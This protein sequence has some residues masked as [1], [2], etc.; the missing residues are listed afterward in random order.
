MGWR[1][2]IKNANPEPSGSWRDT[3]QDAPIEPR[4]SDK[5][6]TVGRSL[7]EGV[8]AGLSEPVISGINAVLGN[9]EDAGRHAQ[10]FQ[11]FLSKSFDW[12]R[13]KS[14]YAADVE[15]RKHLEAALPTTAMT[16]E[17]IGAVVPSPI[18]I[19]GK[20]MKGAD[21]AI[22]GIKWLGEGKGFLS[23][24]SKGAASGAIG[25]AATETVKQSAE[26]PSGFIESGDAIGD[27]AHSAKWGGGIGGTISGAFALPGA[28]KSGAKKL[29]SSKT[30][31]SEKTIDDYLARSQEINAA[32]SMEALHDKVYEAVKKLADDVD[33]KKLT[34]EQAK[35][36]FDDV[37]SAIQ[38]NLKEQRFDAK[39][40]LRESERVLDAAVARAQQTTASDIVRAAESLKGQVQQGSKAARETIPQETRVDLNTVYKNIYDSIDKLKSFGT[41]EANAIAAKL[42]NY[43][44]RLM[45]ENWAKIGGQE[46]KSRL[47]GL[48][49]I[50]E[51]S[52]NASSFDK[53]SNKAFKGIR[54]ALDDALKTEVPE[55]R[56]A[57][58]K[59]A[60]DTELLSQISSEFG[61]EPRA[62]QSL[63]GLDRTASSPKK[64]LLE[65][66]GQRTGKDF[67]SGVMPEKL[68]EYRAVSEAKARVDEMSHPGWEQ[69]RLRELVKRSKEARALEEA[70][71]SLSQAETKLA[72]FGSIKPNSAGM[73]SIQNK[74]KSIMSDRS[75]ENRRMLEQLS[76]LT[77]ENLIRAIDNLRVKEAFQKGDL[78]GSRNVNLW[79]AIFGGI[80]G[81]AG[82]GVPGM[83]GGAAIGAGVGKFMDKYGPAVAKSILDQVIRIKGIPSIEKISQMNLPPQVKEELAKDLNLWFMDKHIPSEAP[84]K[85]IAQDKNLEQQNRGIAGEHSFNIDQIL[86]ANPQAFGK[87]SKTLT[88]AAARGQSALSATHF[89]LQQ[90]DPEYRKKLDEMKSQPSE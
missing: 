58:D 2:T 25:A 86:K 14:A 63:V 8:S 74:L 3:I 61:T 39:D 27:I 90:T 34:V 89:V 64:A 52:P 82:A 40:A 73:T 49:Q 60:Q 1:D 47:Q 69:E 15:R 67:I 4:L 10:D 50:T 71:A 57:M 55:Y 37:R 7:L 13:V 35:A 22:K 59:V 19:G 26:R 85:N 78:N 66:F 68:P 56:Q 12:D 83:A 48:D 65:Q 77:D 29:L 46:A 81:A 76:E 21:E 79:G 36:A 62:I 24:A 75:I 42:H 44:V 23:A 80:A 30:G 41:D 20:I 43:K 72:P 5:V 11:D 18:N 6:E 87:Y 28:A 32:P 70:Q 54:G 16:S 45:I 33:A 38:L 51:Y 31:V 84:F 17:L 9:T 53:A 88:D